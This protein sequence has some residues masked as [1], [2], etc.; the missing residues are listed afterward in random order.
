MIYISA[1]PDEVYF[2]WQLE[3]QLFNFCGFGIPIERIHILIG[4]HPEKGLN[5]IIEQFIQENPNI[6]IF[7]YPDTRQRKKYLS[8]L[9][10]HILAKHF[11][12]HPELE[13]ETI[14]YHD[15]DILFTK[16]PD[17]QPLLKDDCWYA[18]DTHSYLD[19]SYIKEYAGEFE[20]KK[21]CEILSI[22][23]CLVEENDLSAGGAQYILKSC[24]A[25]FWEKVESDC[26]NLFAYLYYRQKYLTH[27]HRDFQI[28][29]TDMWVVWW[30]AILL[31]CRF[32]THKLLDFCWANSPVADLERKTILHYT[33]SCRTKNTIFDKTKYQTH[34]PFYTDQSAIAT[35]ICSSLVVDTIGQYR[36]VLDNKRPKL[37]DTAFMILLDPEDLLSEKRAS[38]TMR[39]L[40]RYFSVDVMTSVSNDKKSTWRS[41]KANYCWII[42][43]GFIIP[44]HDMQTIAEELISNPDADL[45]YEGK[46]AKVDPLGSHVFSTLLDI[47]YLE[48]NAG[49][50]IATPHT[51]R[52]YVH[53]KKQSDN[54][55]LSG[56]IVRIY[57]V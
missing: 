50:T 23:P 40:M 13:T 19:S 4:Y 30:N 25:Q 17:W 49:K 54:R 45:S 26:E 31:G 18:S 46:V 16:V 10:P 51:V 1:Q 42:P 11:W 47:C 9:R 38:V 15:S 27:I 34:A 56:K 43:A 52:V 55:L 20:F 57:E 37:D 5:P 44:V 28:W 12:Q 41:L 2:L 32:K 39:Y 29:C 8:S 6:C 35:D 3:L 33:G 7:A 22:D 36:A 24:T 14:F 53:N 21:M 48:E